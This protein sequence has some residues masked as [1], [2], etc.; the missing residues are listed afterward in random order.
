[1]FMCWD[2]CEFLGFK[3]TKR[4]GGSQEC[5]KIREKNCDPFRFQIENKMPTTLKLTQK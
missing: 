3:K 5:N 4:Q 2:R 1:M